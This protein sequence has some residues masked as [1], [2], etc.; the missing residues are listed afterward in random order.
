[1]AWCLFDD[2]NIIIYLVERLRCTLFS[3]AMLKILD[4][5]AKLFLVDFPLVEGEFLWF[6]DSNIPSMSRIDRV[7]VSGDWEEHFLD[8]TKGFFLGWCLII[9]LY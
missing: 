6:N 4:F 9:V 7:M 3:L 8:M 1:M 2:F 5:I